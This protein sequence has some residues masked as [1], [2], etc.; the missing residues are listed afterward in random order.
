MIFC[1]GKNFLEFW[2]ER[3]GMHSCVLFFFLVNYDVMMIIVVD[4]CVVIL[5]HFVHFCMSK[6]SEI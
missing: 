3:D 6:L 2:N 4:N 1:V 5:T